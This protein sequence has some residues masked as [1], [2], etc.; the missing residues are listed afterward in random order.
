MSS[1]HCPPLPLD[2][3][4]A[5]ES[6]YGSEHPYLKIGETLD[7]LW[8]DLDLSAVNPADTFLL[9]SFYPY[10]LVTIMQYWEFLTDRQMSQATR[11]RLDMKYA[12]HLPLNFPGI[13]PSRLCE[14]RQHLVADRAAN[15]VLQGMIHSLSYFPE[16]EKNMVCVD[17][18]IDAIC[19]P[20]R[21][22]NILE[23]MGIALESVASRDPNWL[24]TYALPHWYR[25]YHQKQDNQ[26]I[27][28]NPRDIKQLILSIG[29]DGWHLLEMIKSSNGIALSQLPEIQNLQHEW[30][31]QFVSE[32]GLLK[33]RESHCLSCSS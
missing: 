31:R 13:L 14:F 23:C 12:L 22:E 24:K 18:M 28:R 26:K 3:A 30:H 19:L 32:N 2:T 10:S 16:Q 9:D 7:T 20:S 5:A 11:T 17:R 15:R 27:P 4:R 8:A 21:A 25:R 6:V 33:F 1:I 29:N